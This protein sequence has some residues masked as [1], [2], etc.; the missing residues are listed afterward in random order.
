[1]DAPVSRINTDP[2]RFAAEGYCVFHDV[3]RADD[4][5]EA[6]GEVGALIAAMPP[7]QR[8]YLE[9]GHRDIDSRPEW[10]TEPH[11]SEPYW[12]ELCR[13][14]A[15]LDVVETILGPDLMVVMSSLLVKPRDDGMAVRWHQ[16]N[17]FWFSLEGSDLLT[18]WLA[19]DDSDAANGAMS[20]IPESHAGS[21]AMA[22]TKTDGSDLLGLT[23]EVSE[24]MAARAVCLE[25]A[26]GSLSLHDSFLVH[27]SE[28][29]TS[30]RRRGAYTVRYANPK[31]LKVDYDRHWVPVFL[32]RG[33]GGA[34][35]EALIDIRPGRP[36][37]DTLNGQIWLQGRVSNP[38]APTPR[39]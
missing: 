10:L 31:T 25:M 26:A 18:L 23:V 7:T 19:I 11:A 30:G 14:P 21:R 17:P 35:G 34:N 28:M 16:D 3:L 38:P 13:H 8:I 6:R 33:K 15:L 27:G 22:R 32:V 37:P 9:D 5:A 20:V 39:S 4:I 12:L 2:A 1:M 29:N 36:L 24:E